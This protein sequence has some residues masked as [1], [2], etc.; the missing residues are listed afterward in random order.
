[1]PDPLLDSATITIDK[2]CTYP[3]AHSFELFYRFHRRAYRPLCSSSSRCVPRIFQQCP[4]NRNPLFFSVGKHGVCFTCNRVVPIRQAHNKIVTIRLFRR[5]VQH[6][7]KPPSCLIALSA[8]KI[9]LCYCFIPQFN[10]QH[11]ALHIEK[12]L[13]S[14]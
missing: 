7:V 12:V 4:R 10:L 5:L 6:C 3:S 14:S 2:L 11:N 1:M 13:H 8:L 9:A